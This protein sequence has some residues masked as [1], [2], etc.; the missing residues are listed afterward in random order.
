MKAQLISTLKSYASDIRALSRSV[1]AV[2]TRQVEKA[3]V[4]EAAHAISTRWFDEIRP[5]LENA[6]ASSETL[7]VFSNLFENLMKTSRLRA[8]KGTYVS[9]ISQ[10]IPKYDKEIIHAA[11]IGAFSVGAS[12][13]IAPYLQ[14]LPADEGSYLDEAQ[15]CLSVKALKGCI[16]LGWCAT[17]ARI[18][19][20][21]ES[22]GYEKFSAATEEMSA[23]TFGRYKFFKKKEKIETRSELQ[24]VF[25]TN[26]IWV[27]EYLE[28]I[29]NNEHQRLRHCFD[30][31]NNSAHPGQAPIEPENVYAFYSD[32][33][34][35]VLKNPKFAIE[36][37]A[38]S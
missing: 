4:R 11:E 37:P 24:Q 18:H 23:K 2:K 34:K 20:K 28:L 30:L 13:S 15:R 26:L 17:I 35:I 16:V 21:I 29:D 25:D 7:L 27:L 6:Q 38:G 12:L 19:D 32:I 36:A 8:T 3:E 31:R 14:G 9:L 22:I 33:T 10:I 5:T 1:S